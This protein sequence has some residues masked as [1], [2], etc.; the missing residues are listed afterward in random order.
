MLLQEA[1]VLDHGGRKLVVAGLPQHRQRL[2]EVR[3]L[4]HRRG[5]E[6]L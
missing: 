2:L 1:A 5:H 3:E 4:R 6:V